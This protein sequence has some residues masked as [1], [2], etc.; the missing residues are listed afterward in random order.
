ML[1]YWLVFC[2]LD[3]YLCLKNIIMNFVGLDVKLIKF[4]SV[5]LFVYIFELFLVLI[6]IES[7]NFV[8]VVLL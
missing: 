4:N 3:L 5:I 8:N 6:S 1:V 7:M 2:V